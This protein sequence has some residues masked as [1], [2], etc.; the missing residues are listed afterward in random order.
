MLR[1]GGVCKNKIASVGSL[2]MGFFARKHFTSLLTVQR[3][4]RILKEIVTRSKKP[5]PLASRQLSPNNGAGDNVLP[6]ADVQED[7]GQ[8][9]KMWPATKACLR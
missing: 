2:G 5:Q 1:E 3:R 8:L 9:E 6:F 4:S 7:Y